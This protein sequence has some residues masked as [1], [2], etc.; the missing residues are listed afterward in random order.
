MGFLEHWMQINYTK[1]N[2]V[3]SYLDVFSHSKLS[4]F[5]FLINPKCFGHK[6][7]NK[8]S[9]EISKQMLRLVSQNDQNFIWKQLKNYKYSRE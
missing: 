1:P 2:T 9:T 7:W 4:E 3:K 8:A 6:W 5:F